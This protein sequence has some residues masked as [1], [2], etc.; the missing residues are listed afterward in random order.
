[1]PR[2]ALLVAWVIVCATVSPGFAQPSIPSSLLDR[3]QSGPVRVLIR[4]SADRPDARGLGATADRARTQQRMIAAQDRVRAALD[5]PARA[6]RFARLPWLAATLSR[7]ELQR[8]ARHADVVRIEPDLLARPSLVQSTNLIHAAPLWQFGYTGADWSVAILDTGVDASHPF[9]G[10]RVI[11]QACFSTNDAADS[12]TSLC[13]GGLT[14]SMASGSALP[15]PSGVAGCDHGTHVAGIAAGRSPSGSGV[16]RAANI[17]AIQVYSLINS[18]LECGSDPAPC[19]QSYTSDQVKALDYL[20]TR[21]GPNN[22]G[23]VAAANLSLSFP[24]VFAG[25]CDNLSGMG[26]MTQAIDDLRAIGVATIVASGNDGSQ[27]GLAAPSCISSAVSVGSTLDTVDVV[28]GFSNRSEL[29]SLMAPGSNIVSSI[30]GGGFAEKS[31]TSMATPHVAGAWALMK[32]IA[33]GASVSTILN[34]LRTTGTPVSDS[35]R[36]YPRILLDQAALA[37]LGSVPPSPGTPEDPAVTVAGSAVTLQWSAPT[38]GGPVAEYLVAVGSQPQA[39]N[40]GTFS[41]GSNRAISATVAPGTYWVR[42]YARNPIGQSAPTADVSFTVVAP[43]PPG[44]PEDP[45]VTVAGNFVTLRWGPPTSGGAVAEYIVAVGSQPQAANLA[46]F[47]VGAAREVSAVVAPGTYWVRVLAR[48]PAGQSAPSE[49]VSFTV[50]PPTPPGVP[51]ALT[52]LVEGSTVTLTWQAPTSG[53]APVSYIVE[54]GS[55]P[56]LANLAVIDS[57]SPMTSAVFSA[58]PP[59]TYHVRIRARGAAGVGGATADILVVVN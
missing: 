27:T 57:G 32:Q 58:V 6:H 41:T 22:A 11:A 17:I 18:A 40:L 30:P 39:A 54:A 31:G 38:S 20:L 59:G 49:D 10:G 19:V 4:I 28:S 8:L 53:D 23:R 13:P 14:E 21:A 50:V 56:G 46:V 55:G 2:T 45:A 7:A 25:A 26:A 43:P 37:L 33:P 35:S 1:M 3:S 47:S 29:L 24:E 12:A 42:V 9:F 44:A 15:C 52:S 16:A 51:S 48:G 36:S 5:V 34:A